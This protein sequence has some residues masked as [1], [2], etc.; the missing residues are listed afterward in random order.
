MPAHRFL[1]RALVALLLGAAACVQAA[2][3]RVASAFDPQTMDPHAVALLYHSRIV[4]QVH[5]FLVNRDENFKLEP[6]L[7]VSWQATGATNWRFRLRPGVKF[8]DGS[9]FNADDAVFSIERALGPTSQRSFSLKGLVAVKKVDDLTIDFELAAPDAVWPEKLWLVAMMS[10]RWAQAHGV[11]KAQDF[12]GKQETYAVRNAMGTGPF[13]L[14]SYQPDVRVLL[15]RHAA[16]WGAADKRQGNVDEVSFLG[17]RSDATRLAALASGEV[18]LVLD[19]PYQD[20]G[21]LK[22]DARLTVLSATDIGT[23]YFTFDQARDELIQGELKDRNPFKDKR[24]R[25]A[26]AHALNI[27]LIINKVLRGQATP[28]GSF[29][30]PLVDGYLAEVDKRIPYDPAKSRALLAAAGY[31]NGFGVT[32]ECVNVAYREAVCQAATAMLAQ[33]GIRTSLRSSP[34][35]QFFPKLTQGTASFIEF[36]WTPSLDPW[37]TLNALFRSWDP[38]GGGTFNAGRYSNPQL[39][40]LI[41]AV[42]TEPDLIKRRARVGVALRLLHEDLPYVPLYRRTLNWAMAKKVRAVQW[43]NDTMELRWVRVN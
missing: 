17:I 22:T 12:N 13:K 8:H 27:E 2:A 28:A 18:D 38:Q 30:S 21:R 26:V 40:A 11:E 36:G 33:V 14:E 5:D 1:R 43:P 32:L 35:N 31:P 3:L 24:V 41:D 20:V 19:P 7:A 15:K 34:T 25:Q 9:A 4:F 6:A 42:R 39:D 16:Y 23:Q 29:I 10:K 37:A